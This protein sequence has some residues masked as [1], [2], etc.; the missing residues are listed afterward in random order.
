MKF[1]ILFI[2]AV[3][4]SGCSAGNEPMT[5][6][7]EMKTRCLDGVVYYMFDEVRRGYMSPKFKKDG[8]IATC[9][10]KEKQ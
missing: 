6:K 10:P 8:T 4:I 9:E 2:L 3:C 1:I 7:K 5:K